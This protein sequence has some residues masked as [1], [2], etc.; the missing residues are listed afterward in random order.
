[1]HG[2]DIDDW[3]EIFGFGTALRDLAAGQA[4]P[5]DLRARIARA[6]EE[7]PGVPLDYFRPLAA[8]EGHL[9]DIERAVAEQNQALET[10]NQSLGE[11]GLGFTWEPDRLLTETERADVARYLEW[12]NA[13]IQAE[14]EEQAARESEMKELRVE[15]AELRSSVRDVSEQ[16]EAVLREIQEL[17]SGV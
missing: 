10:L 15:L 11:S 6:H 12:V 8:M 4:Y 7:Y 5:A 1:M 17:E 2:L 14:S 16:I 9:C 13:M 3:A